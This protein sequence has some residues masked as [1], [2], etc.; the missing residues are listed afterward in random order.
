M[1]NIY[2]IILNINYILNIIIILFLIGVLGLVLNRKNILIT[3]MSIELMLLAINLNF[4]IFSIY[5]DDVIGYVFVLFILT[6]AA[7]ES[8]IGLAILTIYYRLKN[9][10]RID[11]IKKVKG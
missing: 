8:A 4:V 7:A 3:L 6:I 2:M 1:G 10:I 11:K 5:L 9:T